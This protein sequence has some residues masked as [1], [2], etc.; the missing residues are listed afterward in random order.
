MAQYHK[1]GIR[2]V[3]LYPS[4]LQTLDTS[5][6]S[7]LEE[8]SGRAISITNGNRFCSSCGATIEPLGRFCTKCGNAMTIST[9]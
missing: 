6:R 5:F 2:F 7:K 9:H 4:D 3:S 8:A 1:N